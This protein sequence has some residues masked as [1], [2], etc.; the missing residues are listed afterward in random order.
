[1]SKRRRRDIFVETSEKVFQAPAGAAYSPPVNQLYYGE[2]LRD[3]IADESFD[4]IYL[5]QI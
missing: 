5:Q 3:H 1:M 2:N 4:L